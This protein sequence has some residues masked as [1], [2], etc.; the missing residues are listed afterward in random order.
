MVKW[1]EIDLKIL[2]DNVKA[3][4]KALSKNALFMAVVKA[5]G[6]G[7]G[8]VWVS[9]I[10]MKNGA[11][12]LGVLTV[13][14]G[15]RLRQENIK[16][17]IAILSPSLPEDAGRIFKNRL[18]PTVDSM[19]FLKTLN[20]RA[21]K[22]ASCPYCIDLDM[23]LGRWGVSPE[24]FLNFAEKASKF[25]NLK[26]VSISTHIAYT[27]QKNMTEAEEKLMAFRN[28]ALKAKNF[29]PGIKMHA[30]NSS[31][32]VDFPRWQMD[33]A[34]IGN[35]I[36]GIYPSKLYLRNSRTA[37][38]G[39]GGY[40]DDEK[41]KGP[42]IKGLGRPWKFYSKLISIKTVNRGQSLGYSSEYVAPAKMRIGTIPVG[43]SDGLTMEPA[44]KTIKLTAG[45]S[46]WGM[47]RGKPAPFIAKSGIAHTLLD[48]TAVP[49]A[50]I[51][52]HVLL[53]IRRT[54]ANAKIP[55]IYKY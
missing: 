42:P 9:K 15:I 16:A 40:A 6:Y 7:H 49:E 20:D 13:E 28:L 23:G 47:I 22:N 31:I 50:K 11:D 26:A 43:Y 38:T 39:V 54:A 8:A 30:A 18:I 44:E 35:L 32:L 10:A 52:D 19:K 41:V 37:A 29:F 27:A 36:Y 46:Y 51:G 53:P 34:R 21:H 17:P 1:I 12:V 33:M 4:R 2:A 55:R 25:K 48:L 14:E 24:L 5:D 3:V 45:S